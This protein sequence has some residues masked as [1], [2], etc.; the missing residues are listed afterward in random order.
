[1]SIIDDIKEF[2]QVFFTDQLHELG[3]DQPDA[4]ISKYPQQQQNTES[5]SMQATPEQMQQPQ[6]QAMNGYNQMQQQMPMQSAYSTMGSMSM[7]G[8]G[9][10][11]FNSMGS[12]GSGSL[13]GQYSIPDSGGYSL[14][15][16]DFGDDD[17]F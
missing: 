9:G 8:I 12:M 13:G 10:G 3:L 5:V 15:D 14:A 2:H 4:I 6:R 11:G 16:I 17:D 1:M 7:G